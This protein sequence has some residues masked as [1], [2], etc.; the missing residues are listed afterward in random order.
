M[1]NFKNNFF[2]APNKMDKLKN[3][4]N[5]LNKLEG[6][7]FQAMEAIASPKRKGVGW[8]PKALSKGYKLVKSLGYNIPY[9]RSKQYADEL[10][11]IYL[12][13][14]WFDNSL[15]I[16]RVKAQI[17]ETVQIDKKLTRQSKRQGKVF[18]NVLTELA[19]T[20]K[21]KLSLSKVG[22][23]SAKKMGIIDHE[24][25]FTGIPSM[26]SGTKHEW[27]PK[28][29]AIENPLHT[30]EIIEII[31]DKINNLEGDLFRVIFDS[32]KDK[33]GEAFASSTKL[34]SKAEIVNNIREL[35]ERETYYNFNF[36]YTRISIA[37]R[38]LHKGGSSASLDEYLKGRKG[39]FQIINDDDLC[40]HRCL[41]LA[42]YTKEQFNDYKKGKR[43]IKKNLNKVLEVLPNRK[44]TF[45]DFE[46]YKE[47]Q[48]IIMGKNDDV[49]YRTKV[50]CDDKVFLYYDFENEHYHLITNMNTFTRTS[51]CQRTTM[52]C[53]KCERRIKWVDF[54]GHK[55]KPTMCK[56][57]KCEFA[58]EETLLKE[59]I[60]PA[61]R[62]NGG[63]F[64]RCPI[65]TWVAMVLNAYRITLKMYALIK[66]IIKVS[67]DGNARVVNGM[68]NMIITSAVKFNVITVINIFLTNKH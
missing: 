16:D 1:E 22:Q 8:F 67:I 53:D 39:F 19:S 41:A 31:I 21:P 24:Y 29:E 20:T 33:T 36:K 49:L 57:C 28:K 4:L 27:D 64:L 55:C 45:T 56:S 54:R 7:I 17:S 37:T 2:L 30:N 9:G 68:A 23:K 14:A 18:T 47:K 58:S 10:V 66:P 25:V 61:I 48:V 34:T 43:S 60:M 44:L 12:N 38:K 63:D 59:H 35:L 40:G 51:G 65:V 13:Q 50:Q 15:K 5:K 3:E 62:V 26:F 46:D 11:N 6:R 32:F 52:W 42:M